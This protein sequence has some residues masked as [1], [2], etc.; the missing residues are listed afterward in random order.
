MCQ[1]AQANL[2]EVRET[3][4]TWEFHIPWIDTWVYLAGG[5]LNAARTHKLSTKGLSSVLNIGHTP[6]PINPTGSFLLNRQSGKKATMQS[7]AMTLE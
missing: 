2:D 4:S 5:V 6:V 1:K 7:M 3:G